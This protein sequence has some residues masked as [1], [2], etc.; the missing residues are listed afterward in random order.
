M[1]TPQPRDRRKRKRRSLGGM[2]QVLCMAVM[3]STYAPER[4]EPGIR[5]VLPCSG[6][7]SLGYSSRGLPGAFQARI[8]E[9]EKAENTTVIVP[10]AFQARI[11]ETEKAENTTILSNI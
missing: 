1:R 4:R 5:A 7:A 8:P 9:T 11:P 3:Q 2:D 6:L 10:G